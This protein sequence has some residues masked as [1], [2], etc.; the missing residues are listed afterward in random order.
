SGGARK[1]RKEEDD[2]QDKGGQVRAPEG[3]IENRRY[4][5]NELLPENREVKTWADNRKKSKISGF[6]RYVRFISP[7]VLVITFVFFGSLLT[8]YAS[9]A[10]FPDMANGVLESF[11]S[12]FA[13]LLEMSPL[14]IMRAIFINNATVSFISLILG[15]ILGIFPIIF[16][17]FNGYLVGV[18][19]YVV[20]Q[21][22]GLLFTLLALLPHGIVELPMVFL[23]AA[24]G[25]QLGHQVFLALIGRQSQIRKDLIE[26]LKFYFFW[27]LPLLFI[28]AII[29]TF[30]TPLILSF[31]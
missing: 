5:G 24:I 15:L 26:G 6:T 20:G 10:A 22:R 8:G 7:Y 17:A 27:I 12:R 28:A 19:A 18:V 25:L 9:S 21:E 11:S 31:L 14:S 4:N 13:P 29:E 3:E 1:E 2:L 16:I 30:I 23:S